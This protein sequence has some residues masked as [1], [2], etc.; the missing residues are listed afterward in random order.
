MAVV[1]TTPSV[2]V[3]PP[4]HAAHPRR[5]PQH[6]GYIAILDAGQRPERHSHRQGAVP[7]DTVTSG[8]A[9]FS[10]ALGAETGHRNAYKRSEGTGEA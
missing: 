9:G 10:E 6:A 1:A 3:K 7:F 8:L 2:V 4:P 5:R